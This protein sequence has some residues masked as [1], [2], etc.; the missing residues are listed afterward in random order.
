MIV[1]QPKLKI[2]GNTTFVNSTTGKRLEVP[3]SV[4]VLPAEDRFTGITTPRP[5]PPS[6]ARRHVVESAITVENEPIDL[7]RSDETDSRDEMSDG[8]NEYEFDDFVVPDDEDLLDDDKWSS[9]D[10][11]EDA[12]SED[13]DNE[14]NLEQTIQNV[15]PPLPKVTTRSTSNRALNQSNQAPKNRSEQRTAQVTALL[16]ATRRPPPRSTPA[17]L[18]STPAPPQPIAS[19]FNTRDKPRKPIKPITPAPVKSSAIKRPATVP[20]ARKRTNPKRN[21]EQPITSFTTTT[22]TATTTATNQTDAPLEGSRNGANVAA[23]V[24]SQVLP[25]PLIAQNTEPVAVTTRSMPEAEQRTRELTEKAAQA[26]NAYWLARLAT[27]KVKEEAFNVHHE[28]QR[29]IELAE[30]EEDRLKRIFNE[31]QDE[32]TMYEWYNPSPL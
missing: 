9:S 25:L 24:V 31:V 30:A 14:D 1:E 12:M 32:L 16:E 23:A 27:R 8:D 22:T 29:K 13:S 18:Q 17:P 3:P 2:N 11:K 4:V 6:P 21:P 28:M 19:H 5:P 7:I 20:S 26:S 10:E 15:N